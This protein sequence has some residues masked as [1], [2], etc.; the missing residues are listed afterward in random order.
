LQLGPAA[1]EKIGEA[2][3]A[4]AAEFEVANVARRYIEDFTSLCPGNA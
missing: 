4:K 3:R 1:L 2:A